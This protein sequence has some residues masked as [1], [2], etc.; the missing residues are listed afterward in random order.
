MTWISK[1]FHFIPVI[2]FIVLVLFYHV[3]KFVC[4]HLSSSCCIFCW[5]LR[6]FVFGTCNR[7]RPCGATSCRTTIAFFHLLQRRISLIVNRPR[8]LHNIL[9]RL[10]QLVTFLVLCNQIVGHHCEDIKTA[11]LPVVSS[12][13]FRPLPALRMISTCPRRIRLVSLHVWHQSETWC[14]PLARTILLILLIIKLINL[15]MHIIWRLW[16]SLF[17]WLINVKCLITYDF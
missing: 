4:A 2:V 7:L 13:T 8:L 12:A 17:G 9:Q 5:L 3:M 10:N 11:C 15:I 14:W 1:C 16:C 6:Y